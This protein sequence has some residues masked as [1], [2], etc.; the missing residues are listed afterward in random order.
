MLQLN[1]RGHVKNRESQSLE[2]K[3]SF[4]LGD[5]L[6]TYART[7]V[8]MANNQGGRIVFGVQDSPHVPIGL[9]NDRFANFDPKH[10]NR[11]FLDS[12]SFDV[13]WSLTTLSSFDVEFGVI[14][15]RESER[16]PI[17]CTRNHA[18]SK[19]R[20]GA[21]YFRY[22]A[23]TQEIRHQELQ[24]ILDE[25]RDKEK[26]LWMS[27]IQSIASI[28]PQAVQIVDTM[29]GE[30]DIDG[31]KILIDSDLLSKLKVIKEGHFDEKKG[32]P[33]LRI[34][35]DID[36]MADTSTVYTEAAYPYTQSDFTSKLPITGYDFQ[37]LAWKFAL[38]GDPRYHHEIPTGPK[39]RT[40]K[41]SDK[42]LVLL[43]DQLRSDPSILSKIKPQYQAHMRNQKG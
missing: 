24:Q 43:R 16:K 21:I 17:I 22:R 2:F 3:Q 28:G 25:E 13:D 4:Q 27:H 18:K 30:M 12:F 10:L 8:G 20:E 32:A 38:K 6:Y 40:Q 42:A 5:N 35:G 37:V 31:K 39:S 15:V 23:E 9:Q 36:G 1:S 34:I 33:A 7:L 26:K 29:R 19:L 14:E 11:V 41:Y